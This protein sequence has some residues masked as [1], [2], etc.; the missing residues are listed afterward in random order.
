MADDVLNLEGPSLLPLPPGAV[1]NYRFNL[2]RITLADTPD[3]VNLT[4]LQTNNDIKQK[5]NA[6]LKKTLESQLS[7]QDRIANIISAKKEDIKRTLI[8]FVLTL[9][10][11]FGTS[12]IQALVSKTP[13]TPDQLKQLVNCP[14]ASK[15][16]DIIRKRNSLVKQ[17]NNIYKIVNILTKTLGITNIIIT[18]LN[19]GIQLAKAIPYPSIGIPNAGLP[20]VTVGIQNTASDAL[21]KLQDL[22]KAAGITVSILTLAVGSFGIFLGKILELLSSLDMML[23]Q[24]AE[25][26][27]MDLETINDEINALANSTIETTQSPEGNTYKGFK[28]EIVINER[29]TSKYIQRYAQALNRQGVPVLKTD[30]SFASDPTILIDRLKFIIDSDP[31]ITAE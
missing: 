26:Q 21:A 18:T 3:I 7:V 8:P 13:I 2:P 29:N 9:L 11:S 16:S 24:C 1:D 4:T 25:D 22:L 12:A 10:A 19:I 30:P 20:P 14:T 23:E 17:I 5:E 15:I 6:Q 28:L 31:N 27:N